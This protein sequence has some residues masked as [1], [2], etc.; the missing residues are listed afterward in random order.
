MKRNILITLGLVFIILLSTNA[1]AKDKTEEQWK[2]DIE[3]AGIGNE[4]TCLVKV[5]SYSKKGRITVEQAKKNAVH[6]VLFKGFSGS[7]GCTAQKPLI[8]DPATQYDKRDY[9]KSF[10]NKDH[11]YLKY[12][13]IVS[14]TPEVVKVSKKEYKVGYI[15]SVSKDLLRKDLESAQIIKSLGAGF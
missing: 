8:K 9:F 3:C 10:F 6:G 15:I 13:A 14:E 1:N 5:W 12:A 7:R 2:Y 11:S 4:G